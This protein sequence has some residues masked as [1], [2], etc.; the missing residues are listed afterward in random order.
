MEISKKLKLTLD[1]ANNL[2]DINFAL[3]KELGNLKNIIIEQ[4][5]IMVIMKSKINKVKEKIS[6]KNIQ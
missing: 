2:E 3:T 1:H 5:S 6:G 4:Q